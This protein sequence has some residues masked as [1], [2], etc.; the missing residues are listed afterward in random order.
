MED[1]EFVD[2]L[3]REEYIEI[4]GLVPANPIYI[5]PT[6][7]DEPKPIFKMEIVKNEI[8]TGNYPKKF[9][10]K[11]P[12]APFSPNHQTRTTTRESQRPA[13]HWEGMYRD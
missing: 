3:E 1:D 9:A 5:K 11:V 7:S 12:V 2:D 10:I 4:R 8:N 13:R 6:L